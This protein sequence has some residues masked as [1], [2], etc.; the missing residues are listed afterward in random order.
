M[1]SGVACALTVLA[2][3][4]MLSKRL[5]CIF[6]HILTKSRSAPCTSIEHFARPLRQA[7]WP[8]MQLWCAKDASVPQAA[9]Q[10][11]IELARQRTAPYCARTLAGADHGLQRSGHDGV[12]QVWGW[13]E[14]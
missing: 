7:P 9:Y 5:A 13:L 14:Q 10:P 3:R 1:P 6:C 8:L 2:F 11:F 12:R 4:T